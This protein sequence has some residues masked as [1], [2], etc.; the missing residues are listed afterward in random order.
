VADATVKGAHQVKGA[1]KNVAAKTKS[2]VKGGSS[3]RDK[4]P[5]P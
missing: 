5:E 2:A 3:D 4:K 1:A